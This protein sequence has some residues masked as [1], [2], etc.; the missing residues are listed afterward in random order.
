MTTKIRDRDGTG[1]FFSFILQYFHENIPASKCY[2]LYEDAY[3]EMDVLLDD[4]A[5]KGRS[6]WFR[7]KFYPPDNC[8][9]YKFIC[10]KSDGSFVNLP[11]EDTYFFGTQMMEWKYTLDPSDGVDGVAGVTL[12]S[13]S[14]GYDCEEQH[15][16]YTGTKW[17]VNGGPT[18]TNTADIYYYHNGGTCRGCQYISVLECWQTCIENN[19]AAASCNCGG[20]SNTPSP[21][22]ATPQP[23]APTPIP[24]SATPG[25][26]P[27]TPG[28]T[29]STPNPTSVTP[30]PTLNTPGPT[31][32][33]PGP[34]NNTPGPDSTPNPTSVTYGPT[35]ATPGPTNNTPGPTSVTPGPTPNTPGPTPATPG[36]TMN[37]PEPTYA[38]HN[39]TSV[40]Q[41]PTSNAPGP[42]L[43]P[44]PNPAPQP[45]PSPTPNPTPN[46]TPQPTPAPTPQPTQQPVKPSD[47]PTDNPTTR[48][49]TMDTT[50]ETLV[51]CESIK[52]SNHAREPITSWTADDEA[53]VGQLYIVDELDD[54]MSTRSA[55]IGDSSTVDYYYRFIFRQNRDRLLLKLDVCCH[56]TDINAIFPPEYV[57]RT[58]FQHGGTGYA[59][60]GDDDIVLEDGIGTKEIIVFIVIGVLVLICIVATVCIGKRMY[61]KKAKRMYELDQVE[62]AQK[63]D[64]KH[65]L[66]PVDDDKDDNG[67]YPNT[68]R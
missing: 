38:T 6:Q 21:V 34:T 52:S 1:K 3:T 41:G 7:S 67:G 15:Y 68:T 33:T 59:F 62:F 63:D 23:T 12:A 66:T 56:A 44:T 35:N 18:I 22:N 42:T 60:I 29:P 57:P 61:D 39:P 50:V 19:F 25:P 53:T 65:A 47:Q 14:A 5:G 13:L 64:F 20:G 26:T 58:N 46:P 8:R 2:V 27:N 30:G 43:Q 49:S 31:H 37:T 40:T 45:T 36:P 4:I 9:P 48:P 17:I 11:E 54:F 51:Y 24:T 55:C 10:K 28:P 32:N 16:Y